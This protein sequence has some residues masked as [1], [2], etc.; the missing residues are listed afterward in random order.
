MYRYNLFIIKQKFTGKDAEILL[1]F[2]KQA[3]IT[4]EK[5]KRYMSLYR[6]HMNT[7]IQTV[8]LDHPVIK[9]N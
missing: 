5:E 1:F 6:G 9:Q 3:I 4:K 2:S 7:I 8:H